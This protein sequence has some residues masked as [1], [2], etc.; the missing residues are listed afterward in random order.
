MKWMLFLVSI[1]VVAQTPAEVKGK[2]VIDEAIQALGGQN[3]LTMEDRVETGRAYSYYRDQISGLSVATIYTRYINVPR[4]KTGVQIAQQEKQAFGK[5]EDTSVLFTEKGGWQISWRGSQEMQTDQVERY[6]QTA[7]KNIF[8]ILRV[9]LNEPGMI[10]EYRG[11]DVVDNTPVDVVEITDAQDR[12]VTVD[13]H[14]STHLPTRQRYSRLNPETKEQDDEVTLF[15]RYQES[16]GVA[17]PHEVRRERNGDKT[18]EIFSTSV[19][20]NKDLTDDI[21]SLPVPGQTAKKHKK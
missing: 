3:F 14:Q 6:R 12:V 13:F 16:G 5:D 1:G 21:F 17:W 4:D 7:F 15:S 18:Y 9:R 19:A 10:F 11:A 8:Y 2:K 20:V